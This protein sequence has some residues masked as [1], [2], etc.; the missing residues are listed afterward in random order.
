MNYD[1]LRAIILDESENVIYISDPITYELIYMNKYGLSTLGV[2][3][4]EKVTGEKC[5]KFLQS[6]DEPCEFC[7]N[8]LLK[9]D[10]FYSWIHYNDKIAEYF[11]IKDKLIELN[12][13]DLRL[14][15]ATNITKTE[16]EKQRLKFKL[17]NE[18][19]LVKC[20]QTLAEYND[21]ETA[22][23]KLL[24]IIGDFYQGEPVYIF[25]IDYTNQTTS[26]T[27]EWCVD[28]AKAEIDNLQ[29]VPLCSIERWLEEFKAKGGF[30]ITS[31]GKTVTKKSVE[32]EI[33]TAQG[34]ESLVVAPLIEDDKIVGFLGVDNPSFNTNDLTLLTSVTFF[35]MDDIRKR[36]LLARLEEMSF[37]DILTGLGNRNKYISTL[38]KIEKN[39]PETLGII[40]MDLNGLK[41]MNDTYGHAYGDKM[42]KRISR[43][44]LNIFKKDIFRIGGDEFVV[45]CN[46]ISEEKFKGD[47]KYL[48]NIIDLDECLS[49]SIGT[50]WNTGKIMVDKQIARADKLMYLEKKTYYKE[51]KQMN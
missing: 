7:T 34:I 31:V 32:Y 45:F 4:L 48:R 8:S 38:E 12:G 5:Y 35:V 27:Y 23:N 14:E 46:N 10:D 47:V 30:Y 50:D 2:T 19:T 26:N 6:K 22:I 13:K 51:N 18:Q 16:L 25:E 3:E 28:C 39:P 41:I 11:I 42:L 15:I 33:L 44:L 43:I 49:A 20:I 17:S 37:T 29:N 9:K 40:Y 1:E 36:K 24:E 21:T